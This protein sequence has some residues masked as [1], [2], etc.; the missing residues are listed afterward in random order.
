[1]E[2]E[3]YKINLLSI[4]ITGLLLFLTGVLLYIFRVPL[5]GSLRF[6][7]PFPPLAVAAYI[8]TLNFYK[9]YNANLPAKP[10]DLMLEIFTSAG[11]AALVYGAFSVFIIIGIQFMRK[12]F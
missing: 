3:L 1:M 7:L 11:I 8:F 10:G 2:N 9:T 12:I 5:A 4:A 6:L